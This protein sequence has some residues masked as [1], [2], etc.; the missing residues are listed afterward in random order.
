MKILNEELRR[1]YDELRGSK[2]ATWTNLV[3]KIILLV[4]AL[5]IISFLTDI[6]IPFFTD[7]LQSPDT[8]KVNLQTDALN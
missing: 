5:M 8:E 7:L 4:V 3:V 6:H 1:R 2:I